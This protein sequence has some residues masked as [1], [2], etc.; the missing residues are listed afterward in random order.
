MLYREVDHEKHNPLYALVG[1]FFVALALFTYQ[2]GLGL[3]NDAR[4]LGTQIGGD[5]QIETGQLQP[6]SGSGDGTGDGSGSGQSPAQPPEEP[7]PTTQIQQPQQPT[8][9]IQQPTQA[10][11]I[12]T[13][14]PVEPTDVPTEPVQPTPPPVETEI[15]ITDPTTEVIVKNE[16][17]KLIIYDADGGVMLGEAPSLQPTITEI[18][19]EVDNPSDMSQPTSI[20]GTPDTGANA[21]NASTATFADKA[22]EFASQSLQF[23]K[24]SVMLPAPRTSSSI[25]ITYAS[26]IPTQNLDEWL[27][28]YQYQV[29]ALGDNDV[30][31]YRNGIVT[32]TKY[33]IKLSLSKLSLKLLTDQGDKQ[34][35]YS[36]D[37]IWDYVSESLHIISKDTHEEPMRLDLEGDQLVYHITGD[38][39]QLLLAVVPVRVCMRI[40]VSA[41][42]R[43]ILDSHRCSQIDTL[44]DFLSIRV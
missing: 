3:M 13:Q 41:E 22:Y 25:K 43:D 27:R 28:K 40:D 31:I 36:H 42:T 14:Q 39:R 16:D 8:T 17:N 32:L 7:A 10:P 4:V 24:T 44:K 5:T 21:D 33:S 19:T 18:L 20:P 15:T 37:G 23:G 6:G 35:L 11:Q 30:A 9:I 34:V 1:T 26:N 2:A 12:P 38:S 29:W